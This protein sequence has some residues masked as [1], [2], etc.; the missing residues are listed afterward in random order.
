M[1]IY[2]IIGRYTEYVSTEIE[3]DS[4]EEAR[5][6]ARDNLNNGLFDDGECICQGPYEL[7]CI[8]YSDDEEVYF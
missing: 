2:N 4:Y 7:D 8:I 1:A 3:A 6:I 5:K